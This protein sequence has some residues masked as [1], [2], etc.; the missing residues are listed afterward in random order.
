MFA[1]TV[2]LAAS[3]LAIGLLVMAATYYQDVKYNLAAAT[4][5]LAERTAREGSYHT[6]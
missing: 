1:F 2:L 3:M 5:A 4:K 6:S